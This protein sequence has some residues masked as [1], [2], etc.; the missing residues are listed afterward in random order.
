MLGIFRRLMLQTHHLCIMVLDTLVSIFNVFY[1]TFCFKCFRSV[2][3]ADK[4]ILVAEIHCRS[5][6]N[7]V[8]YL[9]L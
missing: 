6:C 7:I 9:C 4:I 1:V 5:P 3:A 8:E 2:M